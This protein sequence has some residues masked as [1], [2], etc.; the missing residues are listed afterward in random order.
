MKWVIEDSMGTIL[1][2]YAKAVIE[3]PNIDLETTRKAL[4]ANYKDENRPLDVLI[5]APGIH[6]LMNGK[7]TDYIIARI[8]EIKQ[9]ILS[10]NKDS[11]V[12]LGTLPYPPVLSRI[13]CPSTTMQENHIPRAEKAK[14]I[15]EVNVAI[16]KLN[17]ICNTANR[18]T[19]RAPGL[20]LCGLQFKHKE[21]YYAAEPGEKIKKIIVP[22]PSVKG[23]FHEPSLKSAIMHVKND[24]SENPS[25]ETTLSPNSGNKS[26]YH[27]AI[28]KYFSNI[29]NPPNVDSDDNTED[30]DDIFITLSDKQWEYFRTVN[31]KPAP[32]HDQH[33]KRRHESASSGYSTSRP[34]S[35]QGNFS[36]RQSESRREYMSTNR[37]DPRQS[38]PR[39][40][41]SDRSSQRNYASTPELPPTR[42]R[43]PSCR[44]ISRLSSS[45]Q[46]HQLCRPKFKKLPSPKQTA[47]TTP[48]RSKHTLKQKQ[49]KRKRTS[50]S[51]SSDS[52]SSSGSSSDSSNEETARELK[53]TQ[54]GLEMLEKFKKKPLPVPFF[55]EKKLIFKTFC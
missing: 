53:S 30:P 20:S 36:Y 21:S 35:R 26:I 31:Q 8:K 39:S 40:R 51:S 4:A 29:T 19:A 1:L 55:Q 6:D 23:R 11:T 13:Y 15:K 50:H 28:L 22:F 52:S 12:G 49:T 25:R 44:P 7:D 43:S 48:K 34:E 2:V 45:D 42:T 10:W 47:P 33:S 5:V 17:K 27:L 38:I 37:Q 16:S 54:K 41:S 18:T 32:Q 9:M 14:E 3:I 46:E 24:W